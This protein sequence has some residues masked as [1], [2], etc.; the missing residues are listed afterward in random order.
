MDELNIKIFNNIKSIMKQKNIT[1]DSMAL[2]LDESS[3][4]LCRKL[5]ALENGK[6]ITTSSLYKFAKVLEVDPSE[7]LK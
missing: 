1:L 4:N 5:K 7:L 2:L 3:P 6:S